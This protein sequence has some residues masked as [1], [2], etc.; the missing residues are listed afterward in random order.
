MFARASWFALLHVVAALL[1]LENSLFGLCAFVC[2]VLFLFIVP[3]LVNFIVV[4]CVFNSNEEM[5]D[6]FCLKAKFMEL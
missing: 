4:V 3:Y 1:F 6:I 2:F 5:S